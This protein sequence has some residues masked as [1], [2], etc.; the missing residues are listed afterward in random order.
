KLE[1]A[2]QVHGDAVQLD[3]DLRHHLGSVD[4]WLAVVRGATTG[5]ATR[6]SPDGS[7]P[8][9]SGAGSMTAQSS[10]PITSALRRTSNAASTRARAFVRTRSLRSAERS[11]TWMASASATG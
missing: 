10:S 3:A 1:L 5:G 8:R 7:Q 4:M 11:I 6:V 9:R 2:A